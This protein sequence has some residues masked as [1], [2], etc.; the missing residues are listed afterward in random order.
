MFKIFLLCVFAVVL[1]ACWFNTST[2]KPGA[3][4]LQGKW[5]EVSDFKNF[6]LIEY[7]KRDFKFTCDSFYLTLNNSSEANFEQDSCYKNGKW[8]EYVK[9]V[10]TLKGDT[11]LLKG[12]YV[13]KTFKFKKSACYT[14]GSFEE[15]FLY[16]S[17][18]D[19]VLKIKSFT[20]GNMVFKLQQ[21]LVCNADVEM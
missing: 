16:Q 5:A 21:R 12:A 6:D 3:K 1:T 19:S 8:T 17:S 9:G 20:N 13:S 2:Q 4:Y 11:I 15:T 14:T 18:S 10:Y 7:K